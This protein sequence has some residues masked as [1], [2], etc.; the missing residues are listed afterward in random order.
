MDRP[1]F[2]STTPYVIIL[3]NLSLYTMSRDDQTLRWQQTL[4]AK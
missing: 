1:L 4:R 2:K 3:R